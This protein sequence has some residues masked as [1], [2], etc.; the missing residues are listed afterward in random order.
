MELFKIIEEQK[1]RHLS[2]G[3]INKLLEL[4][5]IEKKLLKVINKDQ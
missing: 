4:R 2:L 5:E 1:K 3:Q